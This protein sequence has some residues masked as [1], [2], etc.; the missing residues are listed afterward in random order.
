MNEENSMPVDL[1]NLYLIKCHL[2]EEEIYSGPNAHFEKNQCQYFFNQDGQDSRNAQFYLKGDSLCLKFFSPSGHE[3][4][5][6][7]KQDANEEEK[8]PVEPESRFVPF[9]NYNF[10]NFSP[11]KIVSELR[12]SDKYLSPKKAI[13]EWGYPVV[14]LAK[15]M[16]LSP[17]QRA[18][19]ENFFKD[20]TI[21]VP[22]R[23]GNVRE[24]DWPT[25]DP[26]LESMVEDSF[27]HFYHDRY[28]VLPEDSPHKK[29]GSRVLQQM[30]ADLKDIITDKKGVNTDDLIYFFQVLNHQ[31]EHLS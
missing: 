9:L 25:I 13:L 17:N 26:F 20:K 10:S 22:D 15:R 21:L 1:S 29:I 5:F 31:N 24:T 12:S 23:Y 28:K 27:N 16:N 2:K 7:L 4:H 11:A 19:F 30:Q 6:D 18:G 3:I 14:Q 8:A